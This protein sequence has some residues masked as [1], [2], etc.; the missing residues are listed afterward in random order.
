MKPLSHLVMLDLTHMLAGPYGTMVLADLG[1]RTIKIEPPG[2]GEMTRRLLADSEYAIDGM[3]PYV[4][5]LARN[6]ESVALDLKSEEGLRLF[7]Q[8]VEKA[9][10]VIDNFSPGVTER[11]KIDRAH[12]ASVNPR[13]VTC[14]I[15]GFGNTGPGKNRTA[16]DMVAQGMGGGMS[17]TGTPESGPMR[18]GIPIGDL[19]GGM[20]GVIGIL[21]ALMERERT[22]EGRHVDIAMLDVQISLLTYMAT[23]Y[24]ISGKEPGT[25]GNAHFAH[26]P[27]NTFRTKGR[28]LILA[29]VTDAQWQALVG[30]L[31]LDDL[32]GPDYAT[33]PKR[34][35]AR[36]EIEARVQAVIA[37]EHCDHWLDKLGA[38]RVPCAP[39]NDFAHALSDPQ[40][41]ARD[42]V[43]TVKHP[44]GRE[45]REPGNPVK[46]SGAEPDSFA[47]PPLVGEHTDSVLGEM[48]GLDAAAAAALRDRGVIG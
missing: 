31:G 3:S 32:A 8:L 22:G 12:L 28:H 9:D 46:L 14:S 26:V 20:F 23:M 33:A 11:L 2:R 17:I 10:I 4:M 1:V 47:P 29:V 34:L 48:L 36:A 43:V 41:L 35:A 38:A 45:V 40:V 39:V 18:A 16:F 7:Y 24:F 19:G 42:M 13:V 30:V 6:K 15:T 27:Y 5:T 44:N 37:G 25:E 21:T